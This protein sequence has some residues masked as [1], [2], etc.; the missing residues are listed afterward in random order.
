MVRGRALFT[1]RRKLEKR[2]AQRKL[3]EFKRQIIA[4]IVSELYGPSSENP[5]VP[6]IP[7]TS[8]NVTNEEQMNI[9][10]DLQ[11]ENEDGSFDYT[12][13]DLPFFRDVTDSDY[14]PV[15]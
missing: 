13:E 4:N 10:F 8:P 3:L 11:L 1:P 9:N 14:D 2:R 15:E 7:P 12:L 6:K 5:L